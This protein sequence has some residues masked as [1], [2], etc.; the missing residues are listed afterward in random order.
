[1]FAII[2]SFKIILLIIL[3]IGFYETN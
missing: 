3:D 1:M 2:V